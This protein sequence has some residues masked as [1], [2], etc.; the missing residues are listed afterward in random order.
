[1]ENSTIVREK[2]PKFHLV[3]FSAPTLRKLSFKK[4]ADSIEALIGVYFYKYGEDA[5]LRVTELLLDV[6][7]SLPIPSPKRCENVPLH[8]VEI[9]LG[10]QFRSKKELHQALTHPSK[11][12]YAIFG[13]SAKR[14]KL[15]RFFLFAE[16][17]NIAYLLS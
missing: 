7:L 16:S 8:D 13:D 11:P 12:E 2:C 15:A 4:L 9:N 14:K 5:A 6:N 3:L 10:Y 17:P 1:M